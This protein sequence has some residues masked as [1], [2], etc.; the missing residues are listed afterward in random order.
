MSARRAA[1]TGIV[2]CT[3]G[4]VGLLATRVLLVVW[5]GR[6][7]YRAPLVAA[8]PSLVRRLRPGSSL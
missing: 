8:R 5:L 6:A 3:I 7:V 4:I 1:R 2:L